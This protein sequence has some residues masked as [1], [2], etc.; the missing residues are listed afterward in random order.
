MPAER[1]TNPDVDVESPAAEDYGLIPAWSAG[2]LHPE[3]TPEV[4]RAWCDEDG[5]AVAAEVGADPDQLVAESRS[6]AAGRTRTGT[7]GGG[8][9]P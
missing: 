3:R 7:R 8:R 9:T 4:L 6:E 2:L 5:E 1:Y